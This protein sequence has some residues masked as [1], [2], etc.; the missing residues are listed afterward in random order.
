MKIS[1][2]GERAD[3][4]LID[5]SYAAK[6]DGKEVAVTNKG[7]QFW[8]IASIR[9]IDDNTLIEE[10]RKKGLG[11]HATVRHVVSNGGK[12][13][14]SASEGIGPDGKPFTSIIVFDKQ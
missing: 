13:L 12:T 8:D 14:T 7:N 4:S 3:G 9:Q 2:K 1:A 11:Y 10:R 5:S 6:Y